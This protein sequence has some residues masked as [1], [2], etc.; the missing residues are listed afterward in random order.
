MALCASV[1]EV[2]DVIT[3]TVS[4]SR[5]LHCTLLV[6][7]VSLLYSSLSSAADTTLCRSQQLTRRKNVGCP[8]HRQDRRRGFAGFVSTDWYRRMGQDSYLG[9]EA[10]LFHPLVV[11]SEGVH[12]ARRLVFFSR[13][14]TSSQKTAR[15]QRR[16]CSCEATTIDGAVVSLTGD[17]THII[18]RAEEEENEEENEEEE[19]WAGNSLR[20]GGDSLTHGATTGSVAMSGEATSVRGWSGTAAVEEGT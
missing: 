17:T 8:Q 12:S 13:V 4:Y 20:P 15:A 14:G 3:L 11:R 19:R 5:Q 9:T 16:W 10:G 18:S 7:V 2:W 6:R 1:W